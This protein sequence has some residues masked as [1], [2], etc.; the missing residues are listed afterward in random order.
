MRRLSGRAARSGLR[1]T[2]GGRPALVLVG[3][4]ALFAARVLGQAVVALGEVAWLPPMT[5]WYSGLLPY[6]ALL[7]VQVAI[8]ALQTVIDWRVWRY[9]PPAIRP[10]MAA[11]LRWFSY[12]YALAM[13]V[14]WVVTRT[15]PIPIVFH[16]VLAAYGFTVARVSAGRTPRGGDQ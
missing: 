10:R 5:A 1:P 6:P 16:W 12:L 8:L 2:P 15:H 13:L 9:G 14:R 3:L 11:T 4:T 7:P